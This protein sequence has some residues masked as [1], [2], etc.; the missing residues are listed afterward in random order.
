MF[1]VEGGVRSQ[2]FDFRFQFGD[3][4]L[5]LL[6][7]QGDL[8]LRKPLV[9]M[10][11]AIH[12]PRIDREQNRPLDLAGVRRVAELR[13]QRRIAFDPPDGAPYFHPPTVRV[14]H[15]EEERLWILGQVA[16]GDVLAV[17]AEV[18][19]PHGVVVKHLFF[20]LLPVLVFTPPIS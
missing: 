16:Q 17:A 14:V 6:D 18:A 2:A 12:V 3:P 5:E 7:H 15:Q 4:R 11:W 10:L 8:P 13:L 1:V 20:Q 19:E 9:D